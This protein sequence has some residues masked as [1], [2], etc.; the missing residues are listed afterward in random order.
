[1]AKFKSI[2][3]AQKEYAALKEAI[4]DLNLRHSSVDTSALC[5]L[6]TKMEKAMS[7]AEPQSYDYKSATYDLKGILGSRLV[8][9]EFSVV[10][11]S[12]VNKSLKSND[13]TSEMMRKAG[14]YVKAVWKGPIFIDRV[15][16]GV[17]QYSSMP[18]LVSSNSTVLP[19]ANRGFSSSSPPTPMNEEEWLVDLPEDR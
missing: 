8:V 2:P 12:K 11:A 6:A 3:F 13:V 4:V 5:K 19:T 1:M 15:V 17:V 7:P 18:I 16:Y 9:P 14:E 10:W